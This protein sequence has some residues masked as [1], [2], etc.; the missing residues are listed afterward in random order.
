L[1]STF[2][3]AKAADA[4]MKPSAKKEKMGQSGVGFHPP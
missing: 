3:A 2:V 4:G 1:A